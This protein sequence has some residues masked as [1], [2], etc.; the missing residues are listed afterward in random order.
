MRGVITEIIL[1][2]KY[3]KQAVATTLNGKNT[4]MLLPTVLRKL[5]IYQVLLL[6]VSRD[7]SSIVNKIPD[8]E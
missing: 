5:L 7:A 6:I 3:R 4:I 2:L 8:R 1:L